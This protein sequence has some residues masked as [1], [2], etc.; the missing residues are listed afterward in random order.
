MSLNPLDIGAVAGEIMGGLDGLIT[1]GEEISIQL[2]ASKLG[3]RYRTEQAGQIGKRMKYLFLQRHGQDAKIPKR[4]A[5]FQGRPIQ[6]NCYYV[7][8]EDVMEQAIR[9]VSQ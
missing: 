1:S 6:E 4:T 9:D 5:Y 7:A 8:D 3:M 2:V